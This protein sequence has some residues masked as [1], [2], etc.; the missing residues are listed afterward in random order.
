MQAIGPSLGGQATKIHVLGQRSSARAGDAHANAPS[1]MMRGA[2]VI[3][4][5]SK[6]RP[7][8]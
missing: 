3:A 2:V 8:T 7:V 6:Q 4:G 5:G 1:T